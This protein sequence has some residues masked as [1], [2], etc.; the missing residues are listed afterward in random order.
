MHTAF[1]AFCRKFTETW[2]RQ[3]IWPTMETK[4][5]LWQAERGLC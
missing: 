2:W 1:S 4:D 3:R 5:C